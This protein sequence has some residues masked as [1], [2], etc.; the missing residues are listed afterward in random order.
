M[1]A[2]P[3]IENEKI[4]SYYIQPKFDGYR[5][6]FRNNK[7]YSR[8]MNENDCFLIINKFYNELIEECNKIFEYLQK[9]NINI[10]GLD[11][12][13]YTPELIFEE[14]GILKTKISEN[15]K[16]EKLKIQNLHKINFYIYDLIIN[17]SPNYNVRLDL[18]NK[19]DSLNLKKIV[20]V[21]NKMT[22]KIG[23]NLND[24]KNYHKD[25]IEKGFE[26]SILRKDCKYIFGRTRN[27]QKLKDFQDAEFE[28]VDCKKSKDDKMIFICKN[29]DGKIFDVDSVG[30]EKERINAYIE[31][32]R[33]KKK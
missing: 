13:L 9:Q 15:Q 24:I 31:F 2:Y 18:L 23:K 22:F 14:F 12:E 16:I 28:V 11:G 8:S 17:E 4:E 1:L 5:S 7:F 6:I 26:G 29:K 25:F 20:F 10:C 33:N 21:N 27:L 3:F 30:N 19:L 32:V